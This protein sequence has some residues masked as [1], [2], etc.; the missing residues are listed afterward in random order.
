MTIKPIRHALPAAVA[1]VILGIVPLSAAIATQTDIAALA[2]TQ[3][4]QAWHEQ[5]KE[6]DPPAEGCW[7]VSYPSRIWTAERCNAAPD[8]RSI[9]PSP[10]SAGPSRVT[11]ATTLSG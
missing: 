3:A 8:Y 6:D 9:P 10:S 5:V 4:V 2:K 7:S 1:T 11:R